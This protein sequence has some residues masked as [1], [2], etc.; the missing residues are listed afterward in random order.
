MSEVGVHAVVG[1]CVV[2]GM[3]TALWQTPD[4]AFRVPAGMGGIYKLKSGMRLHGVTEWFW[5]GQGQGQVERGER[6]GSRQGKGTCTGRLGIWEEEEGFYSSFSHMA[7]KCD[8]CSP[9]SLG[10]P[11]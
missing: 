4:L 8:A 2:S 3:K 9:I 10:R 7:K 11:Q 1:P 6:R 5:R